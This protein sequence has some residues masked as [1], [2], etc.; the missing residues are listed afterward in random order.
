VR[1]FSRP[2]SKAILKAFSKT[3]ALLLGSAVVLVV[4]GMAATRDAAKKPVGWNAQASAAYLDQREAWWASWPVA[5]RDQGTQCVSCH[6]QLPYALVRPL[7][8]GAMK[9]QGLSAPEQQMLAG[10]T[11]RVELWSQIQP[12]YGNASETRVAE[13]KDALRD[14]LLEAANKVDPQRWKGP[15]PSFADGARGSEAVLNAVILTSYNSQNGDAQKGHLSAT[16]RK[17]FENMWA[18]QVKT[19][20]DAGGWV[21]LNFHSTPWEGE[22]SAYQGAAFAALAVGMAPDDYQNDGVIQPQLNLLRGYLRRKYASQS[23]MNKL[24]AL[25]ASAKV[26]GVLTA[27]EQRALANEVLSAQQADGGWSL[28]SFGSWKRRDGTALVTKSDG[29]ATGLAVVAMNAAGMAAGDKRIN[30][31]VAWLEKHQDPAE[32]SWA[33]YSLNRQRDPTSGLGRFMTDAATAYATLALET[34]QRR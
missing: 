11:K 29:V 28:T 6:T 17:A 32:G 9:E 34:S 4:A 3:S 21:W 25:W 19:G 18:V 15:E 7:L 23:M 13:V 31:A 24:V 30:D 20:D 27:A 14:A 33:G 2:F 1:S 26:P 16:T 10:V 12:F 8:R 22:G 5:K